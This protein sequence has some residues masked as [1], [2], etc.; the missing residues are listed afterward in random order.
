M[1]AAEMGCHSVTIPFKV[2]DQLAGLKYNASEQPGE[3]VPKPAHPYKDAGPT[4]ARLAGL[5]QTDPLVPDWD[6]KLASTEIDYLA[7][8]GAALDEAIKSD[9]VAAYRLAEALKIFVGDDESG[10]TSSRK[11][12]EEALAQV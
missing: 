9:P 8:G 1:A 4:P 2:I 11:K 7:N 12:C 3:L 6:G 10:E 5:S